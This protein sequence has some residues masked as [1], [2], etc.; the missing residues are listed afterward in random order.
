MHA[1]AACRA[2]RARQFKAAM[3]LTASTLTDW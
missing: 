2:G 3:N 1:K